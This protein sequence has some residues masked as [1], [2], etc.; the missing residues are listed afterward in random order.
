MDIRSFDLNFE[1]M[2]VIYSEGFAQKMENM[3]LDDL[4]ECEE[5]D[6]GQWAS[7]GLGKKLTESIARLVSEFL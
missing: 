4:K 5:V 3:F 1:M 6:A 2:S 7:R